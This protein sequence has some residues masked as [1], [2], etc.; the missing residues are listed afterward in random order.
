M[1]KI[2]AVMLA[3]VISC[4]I[5]SGCGPSDFQLSMYDSEDKVLMAADSYFYGKNKK[6]VTDGQ[7]GNAF[8]YEAEFTEFTGADTVWDSLNDPAEGEFTV[9]GSVQITGGDFKLILV[10][11]AGVEVFF[12]AA[13]GEE[14]FSV[15]K[16]LS[17]G[18]WRVKMLAKEASGSIG[19]ALPGEPS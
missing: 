14:N 3:A 17:T 9:E 7:P 19:I 4:S 11:S 8:R 10:S 6:T 15:T 16:D 5:L 12:D 18:R 13:A 2:F 1:K